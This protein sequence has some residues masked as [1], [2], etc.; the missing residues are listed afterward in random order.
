MLAPTTRRLFD[1]GAPMRASRAWNDL[2]Q[3]AS[4][5]RLAGELARTDI[6]HR[7]RGS[8][9]GPLWLTLSTG[10]MVLALGLLYSQLLG[11]PLAGYLP[12][13][14]IS[15]ILWAT[16]QQVVGD[17]CG[18]LTGAEGIIRQ[19]PLP[20]SVHALRVVLRNLL[21]TAH[22]LP[23]IIIVFA[24]FGI[25]PGAEV[26][27]ALPGLALLS[28]NAFAASMLLGMLCARFRDIAPIVGSVMQ[29]AF[30]LTP[31]LWKPELL[32]ESAWLMVFNPFFAVMETLRG[33]L[34]EGGGSWGAW[35]MAIVYTLINCGVSFAFFVRFRGR[36]AFWV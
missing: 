25:Y 32:R 16:I 2:A 30:F 36:V 31:V 13:L 21:V 1:A 26:L 23:I 33:P 17:A 8:V 34:M 10:I 12:Y 11:I 19:M 27:L 15:L 35:T 4:R 29:L 3:G 24:I 7:Y 5:W 6:V 28:I 14:A 20:Y 9:L 22:N 18:A